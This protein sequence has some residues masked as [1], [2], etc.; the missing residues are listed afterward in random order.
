L[1]GGYRPWGES[2][3]PRAQRFLMQ[4]P[5]TYRVTGAE[6]REATTV[7]ISASGV[8]FV[9]E[10]AFEC[11]L[12]VE[13]RLVLPAPIADAGQGRVL[14]QGEIVRVRASASPEDRPAVA[15]TIVRYHLVHADEHA[16]W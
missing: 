13:M 3:I 14:C 9:A 10:S 5:M 6:W 7:N 12:R 4:I 1:I 11:G 15:A 2:M 16:E 8:L